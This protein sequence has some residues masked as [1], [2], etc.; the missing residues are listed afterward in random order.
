MESLYQLKEK[1]GTMNPADV[2]MLNKEISTYRVDAHQADLD[3]ESSGSKLKQPNTYEKIPARVCVEAVVR[4]DC[5]LLLSHLLW[6][7][8]FVQ[9]NF[10]DRV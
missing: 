6:Q 9:S 8:Q 5:I 7:N 10:F 3:N 4:L 1:I 2:E